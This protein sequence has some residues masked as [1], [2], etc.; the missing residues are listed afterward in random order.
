[1]VVLLVVMIAIDSLTIYHRYV[2][3]ITVLVG[4]VG[5]LALDVR[6]VLRARLAP[7]AGGPDVDRLRRRQE[8]RRQSDQGRD[9][10]KDSSQ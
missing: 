7:E 9:Q 6:V 2:F 4:V 10:G 1:M 5:S 3:A 8:R